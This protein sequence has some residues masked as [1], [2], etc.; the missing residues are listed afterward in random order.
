MAT[1]DGPERVEAEILA[2]QQ[3]VAALGYEIPSQALAEV[4]ALPVA[5]ALQVLSGLTA[6]SIITPGGCLMHRLG[7]HRR[8]VPGEPQLHPASGNW[9]PDEFAQNQERV[10]RVKREASPTGA[11]QMAGAASAATGANSQPAAPG[12]AS[13]QPEPGSQPPQRPCPPPPADSPQRISW[14]LES[15]RLGYRCCPGCGEQSDVAVR[16]HAGALGS[17]AVRGRSHQPCG[18][19]YSCVMKQATCHGIMLSSRRSAE[20]LTWDSAGAGRHDLLAINAPF[21]FAC[22][23]RYDLLYSAA[24]MEFVNVVQMSCPQCEGPYTG[25]VVR[26]G[27]SLLW[28][29]AGSFATRQNPS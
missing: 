12:V 23:V 21:C 27:D 29:Y 20:Q 2:L 13:E 11:S 10:K 4:R 9:V 25:T 1:G 5:T 28:S 18:T 16:T 6:P 19:V 15:L 14:T 3:H 8:A 17:I 26:Q 7:Q 22:G 24:V